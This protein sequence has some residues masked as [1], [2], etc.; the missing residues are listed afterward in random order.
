M[1]TETFLNKTRRVSSWDDDKD[2]PRTYKQDRENLHGVFQ[3]PDGVFS[4]NGIVVHI[5]K[6]EYTGE[7]SDNVGPDIS[8]VDLGNVR[9]RIAV[10]KVHLLRAIKAQR[11]FKTRMIKASCNSRFDLSAQSKF[12][13]SSTSLIHL[14]TWNLKPKRKRTVLYRHFGQE[15]TFHIDP[16]YFYDAIC[17]TGDIL[18]IELLDRGLKIYSDDIEVWICYMVPPKSENK[19]IIIAQWIA[20]E[21]DS[22]KGTVEF[23]GATMATRWSRGL[24]AWLVDSEWRTDCIE[25]QS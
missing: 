24:G 23:Q 4:T 10:T 1:K 22:W 15:W 13:N 17:A 11:A 25:L 7:L 21:I 18:I 8:K 6:G 16:K 19:P 9:A 14:D 3:H 12:G 2:M 20:P 5:W